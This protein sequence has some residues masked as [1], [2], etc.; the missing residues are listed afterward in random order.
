MTIHCSSFPI[1]FILLGLFTAAESVMLGMVRSWWIRYQEH[2]L[3]SSPPDRHPLRRPS[4]PDC[5]RSYCWNCHFVDVVFF[6][7]TGVPGCVRCR[8]GC[9]STRLCNSEECHIIISSSNFGTIV[10][11][12]V[13]FREDCSLLS[14]QYKEVRT[15]LGLSIGH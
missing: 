12:I 6:L 7:D 1:N 13:F 11:S 9:C 10:G 15:R 14:L 4:C 3:S 2:S 8:L 5:R